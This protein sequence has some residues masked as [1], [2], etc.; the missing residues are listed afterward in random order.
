MISI[1]NAKKQKKTKENESLF[2]LVNS[3]EL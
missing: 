3:S 2:V 1:C